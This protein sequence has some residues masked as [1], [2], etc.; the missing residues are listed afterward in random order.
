M[1]RALDNSGQW[2]PITGDHDVFDVSTRGGEDL[3]RDRYDALVAAMVD[4]GA[5]MGV[6]HGAHMY[7]TPTT[8]Y[9]RV[10]FAQVIAG[11]QRGREP[12]IRFVPQRPEATVTWAEGSD[13]GTARQH[14][15]SPAQPVG[16]RHAAGD[17]PERGLPADNSGEGRRSREVPSGAGGG[18]PVPHDGQRNDGPGRDRIGRGG[19]EPD[20]PPV[21]PSGGGDRSGR[22]DSDLVA[23]TSVAFD[24]RSKRLSAAAYDAV[25]DFASD[26]ARMSN[27]E[28]AKM[29]VFDR[30]RRPRERT[31]AHAVRR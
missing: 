15:D 17:G 14:A 25:V 21:P 7:W 23:A 12:L 1:I 16:G 3:T 13:R 28:L 4:P 5:D 18:S 19:A 24:A 26:L 31:S 2:R 10:V 29:T 30:G 11:H 6:M 22:T 8:E 9:E 20:V 27:D